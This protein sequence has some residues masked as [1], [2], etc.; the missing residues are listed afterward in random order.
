VGV[1]AVD[2]IRS[3]WLGAFAGEDA[4]A[5]VIWALAIVA[6]LAPPVAAGYA[7]RADR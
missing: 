4:W 6:L 3:L 7:R 5:T 1:V 2:A